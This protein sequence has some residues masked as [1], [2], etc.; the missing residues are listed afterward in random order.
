MRAFNRILC[1]ILAVAIAAAGILTVIE[2]IA[3]ATD[4]E[5]VI[6]KWHGTVGDLASNEWKTAG[7]RVVAIV[8]ILVGLLLLLFAL[9]RGKP[10][11]V[12]LSTEAP[13]VDMTTTRRSLQRSLATTATSVDGITDASVKVKRRTIVVKAR[14]AGGVTKEDGREKLTDTMQGRLDRLS[15]AE[16]KRLKVKV[17]PDPDKR[18]PEEPAGLTSAEPSN[19]TES[20]DREPVGASG[21]SR[22]SDSATSSGGSA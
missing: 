14:A 7:P 17:V 3:A 6:V 16:S 20:Q 9:R 8:L 22:G 11:T 19:G 2:V 4:N 13:S 5:P 18:T 21:S 15:L 10:A 12:A 1:V